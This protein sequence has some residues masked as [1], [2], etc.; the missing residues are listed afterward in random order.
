MRSK[1]QNLA[2]W[3]VCE[4]YRRREKKTARQ[5]AHVHKCIGNKRIASVPPPSSSS[6]F[7]LQLRRL[8]ISNDHRLWKTIIKIVKSKRKLGGC[9]IYVAH[10]HRNFLEKK[11]DTPFLL[12]FLETNVTR[13]QK[14]CGRHICIRTYVVY[15]RNVSKKIILTRQKRVCMRVWGWFFV[16]EV[17]AG[18]EAMGGLHRGARAHS[19]AH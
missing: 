18:G 8:Q 11:C 7:E 16:F 5:A 17:P 2:K 9:R 1:K 3:D 15:G 14:A 13:P 4:M 10:G 6:S 19:R 12:K